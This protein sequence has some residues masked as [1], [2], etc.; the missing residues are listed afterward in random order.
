M[1]QKGRRGRRERNER[2][3]FACKQGC[4]RPKREQIMKSDEIVQMLTSFSKRLATLADQAH[5]TREQA[6][7]TLDRIYL[8]RED[9]EQMRRRIMEETTEDMLTKARR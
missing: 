2:A 9:V 1:Y 4:R 8:L 3:I 5:E 6:Q 7:H